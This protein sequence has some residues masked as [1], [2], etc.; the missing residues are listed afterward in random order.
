MKDRSAENIIYNF[1]RLEEKMDDNKKNKSLKRIKFFNKKF[2]VLTPFPFTLCLILMLPVIAWSASV[3][4]TW[5]RNQEPD[6]AGYRIYYG[7]QSGIYN[8]TITINDSATQP[9]ERNY[10][11]DGL[12][13]GVTYYFAL[14]TFDQAGQISDYSAEASQTIPC[15]GGS[16]TPIGVDLDLEELAGEPLDNFDRYPIFSGD[17][18]GDGLDDI[19]FF[20]YNGTYVA[21][22]NGSGFDAP[23]LWIANFTYGAGGWVSQDRYPRM[24]AD[25]NGDGLADLIAFGY[26]GVG[27]AISNGAGFDTPTWW[28]ANFTYGAGG[29][30]SQKESP[31]IVLDLN[32]DS[33][34]DII[35][36]QGDNVLLYIQ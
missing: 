21:L 12:G 3:T 32:G 11:V 30:I 20:G 19:V 28:I 18:N 36:L 26:R 27:F 24:L 34:A 29:W 10:T 15:A 14:K 23:S 7:T 9:L 6:I 17:V 16:T 22:S 1:S 25:V 4:M 35:G 2:Y 31:R 13:E 33:K 8:N 5:D